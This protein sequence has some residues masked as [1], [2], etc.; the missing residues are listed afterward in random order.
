MHVGPL[1]NDV[2]CSFSQNIPMAKEA[3]A[4]HVPI[5]AQLYMARSLL[6][7]SHTRLR[8]V[9][10]RLPRDSFG[11]LRGVPARFPRGGPRG[12]RGVSAG[13]SAGFPGG[14]GGF[15]GVSARNSKILWIT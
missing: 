12:F 7:S 6:Q 9:F 13:V 2:T 1:R 3:M 15:R 8:V 5:K 4:S 14:S 10:G 11:F